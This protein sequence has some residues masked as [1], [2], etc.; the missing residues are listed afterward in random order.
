M[1]HGD[2]TVHE[3]IKTMKH[4]I[5]GCAAREDATID[6]CYHVVGKGSGSQV[7]IDAWLEPIFG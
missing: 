1:V 7:N 6:Q 2:R 3:L 4:T 5:G